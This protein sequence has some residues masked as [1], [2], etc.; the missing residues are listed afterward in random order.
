M[1]AEDDLQ[2]R[3]PAADIATAPQAIP[4]RRP[5]SANRPPDNLAF[6]LLIPLGFVFCATVLI[7]VVS[8]LGDQ[9]IPLK[10]LI[11][12]YAPPLLAAEVVAVVVDGLIAMTID[13]RRSLRMARLEK[14][15]SRPE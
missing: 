2:Q 6:K 4:W 13:R 10:R 12:R 5:R 7:Y 3:A 11:T 15:N 8:G 9:T 1:P 14:E